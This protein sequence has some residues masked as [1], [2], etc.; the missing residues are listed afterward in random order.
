MIMFVPNTQV[1]CT[2]ECRR[3]CM[4][5]WDVGRPACDGHRYGGARLPRHW[6]AV[7]LTMPRFTIAVGPVNARAGGFDLVCMLCLITHVLWHK[8]CMHTGAGISAPPVQVLNLNIA[9][10]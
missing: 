5:E 1:N 10:F 7:Q 6:Q 4:L 2:G 3:V 9:R 8:K